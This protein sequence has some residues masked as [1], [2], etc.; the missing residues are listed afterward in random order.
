MSVG[1]ALKLRY[2]KGRLKN[3]QAFPYLLTLFISQA[4]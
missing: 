4:V 1:P 2:S 3:F